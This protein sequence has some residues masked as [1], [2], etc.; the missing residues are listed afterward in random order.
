MYHFSF[1]FRHNWYPLF[2]VLLG[3]NSIVDLIP[4]QVHAVGQCLANGERI[5]SE[6][7]SALQVITTE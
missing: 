4:K 5:T 2:L 7:I 1:S 3:S 6:D